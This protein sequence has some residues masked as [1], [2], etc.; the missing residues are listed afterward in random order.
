MPKGNV[1]MNPATRTATAIFVAGILTGCAGAVTSFGNANAA[2]TCEMG[3]LAYGYLLGTPT[4]SVTT[5][6]PANWYPDTTAGA[7]AAEQSATQQLEQ[8][9]SGYL[10]TIH[11]A[12]SSALSVDSLTI[13]VRDG[14]GNLVTAWTDRF[15]NTI[16][17]MPGESWYATDAFENSP[18]PVE[19]SQ[20][21][22]LHDTCAVTI[23]D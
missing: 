9:A 10:T 3:W 18:K 11:N 2:A 22:Y 6:Y 14:Q 19:V 20:A 12:G 23:G 7:N 17:V 8:A 21:T 1:T 4:P 5:A 16:E 15:A 13:L